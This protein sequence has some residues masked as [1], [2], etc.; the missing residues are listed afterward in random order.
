MSK[1]KIISKNYPI[2]PEKYKLYLP[3]IFL[4]NEICIRNNINKAKELGL[5]VKI[6]VINDEVKFTLNDPLKPRQKRFYE[7]RDDSRYKQI[8][9]R[10]NSLYR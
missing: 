1:N 6:E 3:K 7:L 9:N 4:L 8:L 2:S 10:L 5:E